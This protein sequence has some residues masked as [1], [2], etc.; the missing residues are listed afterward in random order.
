MNNPL[1]SITAVSGFL[2]GDIRTVEFSLSQ[3]AYK[4]GLALL[5]ASVRL[6]LCLSCSGAL[7]DVELLVRAASGAAACW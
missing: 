2:C 3:E 5:S 7:I 4:T 1:L 6:G